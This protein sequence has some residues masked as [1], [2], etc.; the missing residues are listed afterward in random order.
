MWEQKCS[1]GAA[2]LL[3]PASRVWGANVGCEICTVR[4]VGFYGGV[5]VSVCLCPPRGGREKPF[6]CFF[7][8]TSRSWNAT[9]ALFWR[10]RK[11][12]ASIELEPCL[13]AILLSW[14]L[15]RGGWENM[16]VSRCGLSLSLS[17]SRTHTHTHTGRNNKPR[18]SGVCLCLFKCIGGGLARKNN[19]GP[20]LSNQVYPI[21]I[22]AKVRC[23]HETC[24]LNNIIHTLNS[25]HNVQIQEYYRLCKDTAV[26]LL[27][28]DVGGFFFNRCLIAAY[29]LSPK[30]KSLLS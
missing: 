9:K 1:R 8:R 13:P 25:F 16:V 23:N 4:A 17:P 12:P 30:A 10:K 26:S 22:R 18:L 20:K 29:F 7:R 24:T 3:A 14:L 5:C 19:T 6:L 27:F 2:S 15:A 21:H 28:Q 11:T